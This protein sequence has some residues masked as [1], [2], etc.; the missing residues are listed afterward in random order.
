MIESEEPFSLINS[1]TKY[2][3]SVEDDYIHELRKE[4]EKI[5][6]DFNQPNSSITI[7]ELASVEEEMLREIKRVHAPAGDH[8]EAR[9]NKNH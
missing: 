2:V 8:E 5:Y 7:E 1:A 6:H 9:S 3:S 4:R